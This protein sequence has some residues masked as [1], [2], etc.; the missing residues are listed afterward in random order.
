MNIT[1][2]SLQQTVFLLT[3]LRDKWLF[4]EKIEELEAYYAEQMK[5]IRMAVNVVD[6]G[7]DRIDS[8]RRPDDKNIAMIM[9]LD[10]LDKK[11]KEELEPLWQEIDRINKL[12]DYILAMNDDCGKALSMYYPLPAG[13]NQPQRAPSFKRDIA[14]ELDIDASDVAPLLRLGEKR[15]AIFLLK[16]KLL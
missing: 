7:A 9:R 1:A 4:V 15:C 2:L 12:T 14:E 13:R 3:Q 16:E 8:N 11:K 6:Y 10:K 5:E